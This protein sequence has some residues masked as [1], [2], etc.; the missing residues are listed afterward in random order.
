MRAMA[1]L[2]SLMRVA[3]VQR[4]LAGEAG[5]HPEHAASHQDRFLRLIFWTGR[6]GQDGKVGDRLVALECQAD[7]PVVVKFLR[8]LGEPRG[9]LQ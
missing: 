8:G 3:P 7:L 6:N 2:P 1:S 4:R 5:R 9:D